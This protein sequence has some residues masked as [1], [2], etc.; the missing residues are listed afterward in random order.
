MATKNTSIKNY[1]CIRQKLVVHREEMK[2]KSTAL[3]E[4]NFL[5]RFETTKM[6]RLGQA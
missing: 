5:D 3:V 4:T 6:G 1:L 2:I